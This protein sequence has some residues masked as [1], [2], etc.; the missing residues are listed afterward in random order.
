MM[1][2]IGICLLLYTVAESKNSETKA[3]YHRVLGDKTA[4]ECILTPQRTDKGWS[5]TGVT[6]RGT[7]TMTVT[8]RYDTKDRL[9]GAEATLAKGDKKKVVRVTVAGNKAKVMRNGLDTQEFDVPAGVIVT[10]APD[11]TDTFLLCRHYNLK[12]G[13]KQEFAG[14]WIHPE[15]TAQRLTFTIE[16]VATDSIE[17]EGKKRK[18]GRFL[19]RIRNNSDVPSLGGR[20]GADDQA[21]LI[22][23][24]GKRRHRAGS[25]RLRENRQDVAPRAI[26]VL[27]QTGTNLVQRPAECRYR[28]TLRPFCGAVKN[29]VTP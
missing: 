1:R 10:S 3:R 7:T 5:I 15:Q 28:Q 18:L 20:R 26:K 13:G 25:G 11:W 4:T 22:A 9:T 8:A 19:I 17:H 29:S 21:D 6:E 14:L 23:G 12:K 24:Q 27:R 2:A 16:Q